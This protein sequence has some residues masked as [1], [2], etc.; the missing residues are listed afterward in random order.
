[1]YIYVC[2][3]VCTYV[4]MWST[5]YGC[6]YVCTSCAYVCMYG[7]CAMALSIFRSICLSVTLPC[8]FA[9]L[10]VFLVFF[11]FCLVLTKW[12][13][14]PLCSV[15]FCSGSHL[16]LTGSLYAASIK[17]DGTLDCDADAIWLFCFAP[18]MCV[19]GSVLFCLLIPSC[20]VLSRLSS[21]LFC[22]CRVLVLVI[23]QVFCSF[24]CLLWPGLSVVSL[25]PTGTLSAASSSNCSSSSPPTSP[26]ITFALTPDC[27]STFWPLKITPTYLAPS[28]TGN[29][30]RSGTRFYF[31]QPPGNTTGTYGG[32]CIGCAAIYFD[33]DIIVSGK[34]V[35]LGCLWLCCAVYLSFDSS[36][37]LPRRRQYIR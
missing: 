12:G 15:W 9:C 8:L 21:C 36:I 18:L 26:A 10:P 2:K 33:S 37:F 27:P 25:F 23:L 20:L 4:Y 29:G 35:C 32:S 22:S 30:T 16:Y 34:D 11:L 24:F 7:V 1:M 17:S 28:R 19:F 14:A 5:T 13:S 31:S 6:M 3:Y